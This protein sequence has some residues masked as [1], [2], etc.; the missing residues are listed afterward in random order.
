[1]SKYEIRYDPIA[2]PILP[3][4][5]WKHTGWWI[6]GGWNYVSGFET[7]E[8]AKSCIDRCIAYENRVIECIKY[9]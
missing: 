6:F 3:Y 9:S 2:S 8:D 5:V 4:R 1:M 7:L